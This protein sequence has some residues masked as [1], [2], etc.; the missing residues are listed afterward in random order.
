MRARDVLERA[1]RETVCPW[2]SVSHVQH[3]NWFWFRY[4]CQ[5]EEKMRRKSYYM[6]TIDRTLFTISVNTPVITSNMTYE[7]KDKFLPSDF[8]REQDITKLREQIG[9]YHIQSITYGRRYQTE[10][11]LTYTSEDTYQK[12]AGEI[13]ASIG[14]GALTVSAKVSVEVESENKEEDF[15]MVLASEAFGFWKQTTIPTLDR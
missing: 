10:V 13:E 3:D 11:E 1:H 5:K 2:R 8:A 7:E 9:E 15:S 12:I 6:C 4:F 14:V